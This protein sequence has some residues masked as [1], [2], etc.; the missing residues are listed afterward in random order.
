MA[1]MVV[2]LRRGCWK[3]YHCTGTLEGWHIPKFRIKLSAINV[4]IQ[5]PLSITIN[6]APA[7]PHE[8]TRLITRSRFPRPLYLPLCPSI[9]KLYVQQWSI[10]N[11]SLQ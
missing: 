4:P 7:M 3:R 5:K 10:C 11:T 1:L 9:R 8:N 6:G 2:L